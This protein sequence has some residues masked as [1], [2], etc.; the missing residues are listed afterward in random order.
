[1]PTP[2]D[3]RYAIEWIVGAIVVT[4]LAGILFTLIVALAVFVRSAMQAIQRHR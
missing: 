3:F 4:V 2:D 1:M